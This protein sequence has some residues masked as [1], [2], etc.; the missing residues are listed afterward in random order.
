VVVSVNLV[1]GKLESREETSFN[2]TDRETWQ[3]TVPGPFVAGELGIDAE[4][5]SSGIAGVRSLPRST[6]LEIRSCTRL[7][8]P[9]PDNPFRGTAGDDALCGLPGNDRI[10]GG[11]GNDEL[12]GYNGRDVVRGEEGNDL[13]TGGL[14][15]DLLV[16]GPGSDRLLGDSG[17]DRLKGG[18]G[19]DTC[20]D[21]PDDQA[22]AC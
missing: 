9:G 6:S 21:D 15:A 8:T 20:V 4:A 3:V 13:L 14:G 11:P 18:P 10:F 16:G 17:R 19:A 7:G 22:V 12:R 1:Q 5:R 2:C